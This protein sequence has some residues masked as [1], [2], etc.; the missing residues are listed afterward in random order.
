M[1]EIN[2]LHLSKGW[3]AT[4]PRTGMQTFGMTRNE[5]VKRL[6]KLLGWTP[7]EA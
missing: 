2:V 6:M 5:A 3:L 4:D 7:M 1:F